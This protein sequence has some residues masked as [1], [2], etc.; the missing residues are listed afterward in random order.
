MARGYANLQFHWNDSASNIIHNLGFG[1]ELNK[2]AAQIFYTHYYDYIPYSLQESMGSLANNVR[3]TATNDHATITH[4]VRYAN[5]QF[6]ADAGSSNGKDV[7]VHRTRVVHPLATSRWSEWA[8][9]MHKK[10]I[11]ADIDEA[12]LKYRKPTRSRKK[13]QKFTKDPSGTIQ[14]EDWLALLLALMTGGTS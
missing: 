9:S 3:I 14:G 5:K 8:W 13:D 12:R 11:T 10:E 4:L 1:R 7:G 2:E 6:Y